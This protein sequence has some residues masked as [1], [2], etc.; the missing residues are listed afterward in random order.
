MFREWIGFRKETQPR[1][2]QIS[3]IVKY[4]N[5]GER[6]VKRYDS[7]VI[8]GG[9]SGVAIGALLAKKGCK[10]VVL[11]RDPRLG[12]RTSTF[13]YRGY[14]VDTGSHQFASWSTCGFQSLFDQ[15]G[16]KLD[17]VPILPSIMR[18][19]VISKKYRKASARDSLGEKP[20]E[21]FKKV[22][23][24]IAG[25]SKQEIDTYH[26]ITA[27]AWLLEQVKGKELLDFFRRITGFGGT[28]LNELSAA[29]F[30]VT[31]N[32]SFNSEMKI[33]YPKKGGC[34]AF[35]NALGEVIKKEGGEIITEFNV[36]RVQI[37]DG[38]V[39]GVVGRK[40][41]SGHTM[42]CEM[43]MEAPLIV[44]TIPIDRLFTIIPEEKAGKKLRDRVND[45]QE[46]SQVYAGIIAGVEESLLDGFGGGKQFFQFT[47]GNPNEEWH[48]L[49]TV[50]TY[51][52]KELAPKGFHYFICN[53]HRRFPVSRQGEIPGIHSRLIQLVTQIWPRFNEKIDW[54]MR[55]TYCNSAYTAK[56]GRTGP[57]GLAG[58][59]PG[60]KGLYL[61]GDGTYPGYSGGV[62]SA[63]KSAMI[64]ITAI[65]DGK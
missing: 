54:L 61:A 6:K 4:N 47:A 38:A 19:E 17:L 30:L 36:D 42:I 10:P 43:E 64:C 33:V 3:G 50:P 44:S 24:L 12:G 40:L 58:A 62:G 11:E 16:G 28:P 27:E 35:S 14:R 22:V 32:N 48:A 53:S 5:T 34:I 65:N 25:M 29:A 56:I 52:D 41:E 13:E 46:N 18:Y 63:V 23:S 15:V 51:V 45:Y 7:I 31:L 21:E 39:K 37:E 26:D 2:N 59:V 20:H 8:G 57:N 55:V 1:P 9:T 60:I 49:V